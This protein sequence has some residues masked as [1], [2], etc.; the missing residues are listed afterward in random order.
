MLAWL[1]LEKTVSSSNREEPNVKTCTVA[2]T[3]D[4]N[5]DQKY[6]CFVLGAEAPLRLL[7]NG[8]I[9]KGLPSIVGQNFVKGVYV[10]RPI[11]RRGHD[12]YATHTSR[13]RPPVLFLTTRIS[14]HGQTTTSSVVVVVFKCISHVLKNGRVPSLVP[15]RQFR[16]VVP[17]RGAV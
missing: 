14:H 7:P 17:N 10:P 16:P 3:M 5:F 11:H 2:L 1:H 13:T 6:C 12:A 4:H 9:G 8:S 15:C